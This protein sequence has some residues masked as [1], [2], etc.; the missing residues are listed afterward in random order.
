MIEF[1]TVILGLVTGLRPV[2]LSVVGPVAEVEMR[3]DGET[4]AV[5]QGPPWVFECDFGT[6]IAPHRLEAIA[7]DADGRELDRVERLVNVDTGLAGAEMALLPD[8]QGHPVAVRLSWESIG[9]MAPHTIEVAFNDQPLEVKNPRKIPLPRYNLKDFHFVTAT[10]HFNNNLVSYLQAGFGGILGDEVETELTAVAVHRA[11]GRLPAVENMKGWFEAEGKS[12]Q[13]HGVEK[14]TTEV[15]V[16]RDPS[17]QPQLDALAWYVYNRSL[18]GSSSGERSGTELADLLRRHQG[19]T[20]RQHAGSRGDPERLRS[21]ASLGSKARVRFVAPASATLM[22]SGVQ[23][24]LFL[25]SPSFPIHENGLG[26]LVLAN[27]P[28]RFDIQLTDAVALA[29]MMAHASQ[30]RRIVLLLLGPDSFD[31]SRYQTENVRQYLHDLGV[32]LHVA[33]FGADGPDPEWGEVLNLGDLTKPAEAERQ[34]RRVFEDLA[35]QLEDQRLVWLI[36]RHL[37]QHIAL[38]QAAEGVRMAGR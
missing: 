20:G 19:I 28:Q 8:A 25:Q 15:F 3:L 31:T 26:H 7:R 18:P 36:G 35:K 5:L 23:R 27:P 34:F 38:G 11:K 33:R 32:P 9:Q 16:V 1:I 22:P 30:S 6:E 37:P 4:Q 13:V 21:F 14:G 10:L 24:E 29:G 17:I 2:E 12:L